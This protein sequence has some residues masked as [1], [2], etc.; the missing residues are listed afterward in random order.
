MRTNLI[1]L[2]NIRTNVVL[3]PYSTYK[4]GGKADYFFVASTKQELIEAV[5]QAREKAIPYF[6]LGTGANI[7]FS[8]KGFRGLVIKNE[9]KNIRFSDERVT[10]ESGAT[11]SNLIEVA[12]DR[13]LSGFENFAGIPSTVGGA[14]WQNLHFLSPDRTKTIFIADI[15]ES[16]EIMDEKG[17]IL[18]VNRDFFN[19]NYDYSI[20]H[21]RNLL[22]T[23]AT[24]NLIKRDKKLIQN[25]VEENLKWRNEKQP[26]LSQFP[27]C[28]SVFKKIE[29]IGAGRLIEKT[30]LKGYVVGGAKVSEKHANYIVN[31]G[32]ATAQ[33]VLSLIEIVRDKVK[34]ETGYEL[35]TEIS[36][37]G[38]F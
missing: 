38:E 13:N 35:K 29:G 37:V 18:N 28:G 4:I 2:L 16:A 9:S 17:N 30:D 26:Q 27:S 11:I 36:F 23:G 12:A 8:D 34:K 22:V 31:T 5:K 24:F 20:L 21:D 33:E 10:T 14:L 1:N 25:Q 15:L 19:F 7:L 3:A 32:K 6:I